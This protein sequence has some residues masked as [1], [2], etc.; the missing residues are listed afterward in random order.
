MMIRLFKQLSFLFV[1]VLMTGCIPQKEMNTSVIKI[2]DGKSLTQPG[3]LYALPMTS[4]SVDVEATRIIYKRGPYYAYANKLLDLD[5]IIDRDR[6]EWT[7]DRVSVRQY[8][9]ADPGE[10]YQV[11]SNGDLQPAAMKL[12]HEGLILLLNPSDYN[13][14]PSAFADE[15]LPFNGM[16]FPFRN[17]SGSVKQYRDTAYRTVATD[18]SFIQIP[19][20][21]TKQRILTPEEKAA[22]A[23]QTLIRIRKRKF[24]LVSRNNDEVS[25]PDGPGL[26]IA[27][28][29]LDKLEADYLALFAGKKYRRTYH[30]RYVF[31][32][33][34]T[35]DNPIILFRFLPALGVLPPEDLRGDAVNVSWE[36]L[37]KTSLIVSPADT[38]STGIPSIIYRIPE[39]A[40]LKVYFGNRVLFSHHALLYQ[41]GAKTE[42]PANVVFPGIN[43]SDH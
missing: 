10:Y 5:E 27:V 40:N 7:L 41:M 29:E 42:I 28:R 24:R 22:D 38:L 14:M 16:A 31:T 2:E 37:G 26:E 18:T 30:Y 23:A 32:P 43:H 6:E 21:I 1:A 8:L 17:L 9:E 36:K 39:V 4:F 12:S 33:S 34:D 19:V 35:T 11:I 25:L 15:S 13:K 20:I 3:L